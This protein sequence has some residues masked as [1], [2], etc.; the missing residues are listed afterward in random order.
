MCSVVFH[1]LTLKWPIQTSLSV[2]RKL[3]VSLS[4]GEK[5]QNV[6][7]TST[8]PT[9]FLENTDLLFGVLHKLRVET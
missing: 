1:A 2:A 9:I 6:R 8:P 5:Y 7:K 3:P 4:S